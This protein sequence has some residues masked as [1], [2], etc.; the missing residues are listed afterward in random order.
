MVCKK[1][2]GSRPARG[3]DREPLSSMG[4][5]LIVRRRT[6]KPLGAG[7]VCSCGETGKRASLGCRW[8]MGCVALDAPCGFESRHEHIVVYRLH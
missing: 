7:P 8:G 3:W 2:N 5:A 4:S 1:D 6:P